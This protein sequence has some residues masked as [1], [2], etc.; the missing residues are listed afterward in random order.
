V[1]THSPIRPAAITCGTCGG[2]AADPAADTHAAHKPGCGAPAAFTAAIEA[3]RDAEAQ[4]TWEMAVTAA[5]RG[6]RAVA[7]A[8]FIPGGPPV[9]EIQRRYEDLETRSRAHAP[10]A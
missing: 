7:E 8:A 4:L 10:A 3:M 1:T 9:E 2:Q 6:T 5:S